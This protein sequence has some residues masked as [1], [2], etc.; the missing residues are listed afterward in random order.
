MRSRP[1]G[2]RRAFTWVMNRLSRG[3]TVL[4][5]PSSDED[6]LPHLN[7]RTLAENLKF[8]NTKTFSESALY[9]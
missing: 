1:V 9:S 3:R 6:P 4:E 2:V 5:V 7:R 8:G